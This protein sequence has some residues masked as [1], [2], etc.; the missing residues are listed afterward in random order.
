MYRLHYAGIA[1]H[2]KDDVRR[3]V[4]N[5]AVA[6]DALDHFKSR[7]IRVSFVLDRVDA[8]ANSQSTC[9]T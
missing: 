6:W 7:F 1:A 2:W 8:T 5:R 4:E 3:L 9:C